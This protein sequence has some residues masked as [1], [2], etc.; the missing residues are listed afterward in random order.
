MPLK[1]L[2]ISL[3]P[4]GF[5]INGYPQAVAVKSIDHPNARQLEAM[6]LHEADLLVAQASIHAC[7]ATAK[8]TNPLIA[9]GLW[10]GALVR[11]FKCFGQSESR[12]KLSI[13]KILRGVP[14]E[15]M[16][17]F[18][19]FEHLRNKNI[20]HDENA[21]SQSNIGVIVNAPGEPWKVADVVS[22]SIHRATFGDEHLSSFLR[23]IEHTL[24]WVQE[25]RVKLH[26]LLG[27][28]YELMTHD[29]LMDL[30]S[31][32]Y[33]VPVASDVGKAR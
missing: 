3:M 7:A 6:T 24:A 20:V 28:H 31:V 21:F 27:K 30:P 11:Y 17:A 23:L 2:D 33:R 12:S 15:A 14:V 8:D 25:K 13:H 22:L 26:D 18:A 16:E 5:Q 29:E 19:Y 10:T 1:P 9:E 4:S 32:E